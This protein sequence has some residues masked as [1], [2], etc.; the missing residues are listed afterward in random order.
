MNIIRNMNVIMRTSM[1]MMSSSMII[2]NNTDCHHL[3]TK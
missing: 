2:I 1:M 3:P